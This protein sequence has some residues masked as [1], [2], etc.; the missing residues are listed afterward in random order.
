[1]K[2]EAKIETLCGDVEGVK[3]SSTT[4]V[5]RRLKNNSVLDLLLGTNRT[6]TNITCAPTRDPRFRKEYIQA[7]PCRTGIIDAGGNKVIFQF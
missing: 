2:K 3:H 1:M 6:D 5:D 7:L 4:A